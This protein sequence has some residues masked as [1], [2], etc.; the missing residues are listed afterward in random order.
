MT[1]WIIFKGRNRPHF[2]RRNHSGKLVRVTRLV[3]H[4]KLQETVGK[5]E[6]LESFFQEICINSFRVVRKEDCPSF[7]CTVK[8]NYS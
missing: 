2:Y 6:S 1:V 8:V 5:M 3:I 4:F 7:Q